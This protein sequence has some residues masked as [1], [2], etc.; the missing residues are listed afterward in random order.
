[1]ERAGDLLGR[2]LRRLKRPEA[3]L[4]WLS[5]AWPQIVGPALAAHTSPLRCDQGCLEMSAD[6]IAWKKELEDLKPQFTARINQAWGGTLVREIKFVAASAAAAS[7]AGA[8]NSA[9]P[10]PR[11][12]PHELDND[13]TPFIRRKKG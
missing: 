2:T 5:A 1:M 4:T 7:A 10:A 13:H 8:S 3:A 11:R 9:G 6:G 12:L